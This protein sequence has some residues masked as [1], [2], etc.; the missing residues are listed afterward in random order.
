MLVVLLQAEPTL[1]LPFK[2]NKPSLSHYDL[3][4]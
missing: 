2:A 4:Y 3:T 1:S